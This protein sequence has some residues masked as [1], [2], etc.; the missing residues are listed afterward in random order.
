MTAATRKARPPTPPAPAPAGPGALPFRDGTECLDAWFGALGPMSGNPSTTHASLFRPIAERMPALRL[1]AARTRATREAGVRVPPIDAFD[2]LGLDLLDRLLLLALL[3]EAVDVRCGRGMTLGQLCDAVGAADWS[4]Q[5]A[6]R[7]R[8]EETGT[9]R[10]LRLLQ[11]DADTLVS[12]RCYRLDPRW[13]SALLAGRTAPAEESLPVPATAAARLQATLFR[14]GRLLFLVGPLYTDRGQAWSDARPDAPGWDSLSPVRRDLSRTLSWYLSP[15]GA[16]SSDPLAAALREAGAHTPAEAALLAALLSRSA[17]D[18]PVAWALLSEALEGLPGFGT[19]RADL[20]G[21]ASPLG[22]AGLIEEAGTGSDGDVTLRASS[23]ARARVVP[24]GLAL[25]RRREEDAAAKAEEKDGAEKVTP[26]L[27]LSGLVLAPHVRVRLAEALAVPRALAAA[28]EW[29]S[30]EGL[31]GSPGVALL[32]YGPPGTG[33][34]L[35]AEAIAGE[36]GRNLWRLRTDQLLSKYV[37]E[38]EKKLAA[39][40]RAARASGDVVL[41]DEADSLL[42]S[43]GGDRQRWETSLTNLL[44]QE[45]ESF[46]G[47]VVLTTNR[48]EALDPA[49]ERRLLARLEIGMPGPEEREQLWARHL[50][51]RAPLAADVDLSVL[52]RAY[53]LS[54]SLIRTA[55]LFAVAKAAARP[56]PKRLLTRADL[57][58]AA[59][60]QLARAKEGKAVVGF[61]PARAASPRLALVASHEDA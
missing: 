54:G 60:V 19:E 23:A 61:S 41:L 32:L 37:G 31:L 33:K 46:T 36:L 20:S 43:R 51:P 14:A 24:S 49:L 44:L 6:V 50:P 47:V 30:S 27:A 12:E 34:T 7:A 21:P 39:T 52:A 10:R 2:A 45:I 40:F 58:E 8:A 26:R 35:A 9:L 11:S 29:G 25:V 1:L 48:D 13:K 28:A 18:E 16:G 5:D 59:A 15:G 3:R 53:A 55:A 17:D 38:S 4:H 57:H 22:R 42:S 56:D